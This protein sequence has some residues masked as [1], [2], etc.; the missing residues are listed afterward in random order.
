MIDLNKLCEGIDYQIIPFPEV[1]NDQAWVVSIL[2][3]SYTGYRLFFTGIEYDGTS[4]QL[5]FRLD[6]LNDSDFV[7]ADGDLQN[8]AFDLLT[9]IIKNGI[10]NGSLVIDDKN[11][12][13]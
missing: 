6:V 3:G 8:Y 13:N 7:S 5:R 1:D 11:T 9:D 4:G 12:D 10:A 2:R